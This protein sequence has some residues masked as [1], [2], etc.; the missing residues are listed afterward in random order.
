MRR[1]NSAA[2][3]VLRIAVPGGDNFEV[4]QQRHR[5]QV[6]QT[7]GE[8]IDQRCRRAVRAIGVE[9]PHVDV[10]VGACVTPDDGDAAVVHGDVARRFPRCGVAVD[11]PLG[12]DFGSRGA[13][14]LEAQLPYGLC[15]RMPGDREFPRVLAHSDTRVALHVGVDGVHSE[16]AAVGGAAA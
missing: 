14:Q 16:R 2:V 1:I 10:P 4:R 5:G 7:A 3:A 12:A 8:R 11:L 13:E 9:S 15:P 6:L